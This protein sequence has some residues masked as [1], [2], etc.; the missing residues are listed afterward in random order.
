MV[1]DW[2]KPHQTPASSPVTQLDTVLGDKTHFEGTLKSRGNVRVEGTF[3]GDIT[4]RGRIRVGEEAKVEGDLTGEAVSVS[5]IVRGNITARKACVSQTGRVW[6]DLTIQ[7]LAT[8]EGGFIQ[9]LIRMEEKIDIGD[10]FA[11]E[12]EAPK[13]KELEASSKKAQPTI[14]TKS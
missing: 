5:G 8:E 2:F 14:S 11:A 7:T 13:E 6:G 12:P 1:R 3:L 10:L 4:A 9:G